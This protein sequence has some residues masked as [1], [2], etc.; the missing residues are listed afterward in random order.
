M[1][2]SIGEDGN[3]KTQWLAANLANQT[4]LCFHSKQI[5]KTAD[6]KLQVTGE[7]A[8]IRHRNVQAD[9]TEAYSGP[10]KRPPAASITRFR[11][12]RHWF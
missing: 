4:L 1:S 10:G 9:P 2:E 12:R 11:A 5:T 7:L 3:F 6:G 8:T